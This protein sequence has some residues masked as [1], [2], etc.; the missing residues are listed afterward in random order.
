MS[1]RWRVRSGFWDFVLRAKFKST[2]D[3][4]QLPLPPDNNKRITPV[5]FEDYYTSIP[6]RSISTAD[7]LPKDERF[8]LPLFAIKVQRWIGRIFSQ[9]QSGLPPISSDDDAAL[10]GAYGEKFRTLLPAPVFPAEF[11]RDGVTDLGRFALS[12]PYSCLLERDNTGDVVWDCTDLGGYERHEG[13][14]SLAV[15]VRFTTDGTDH[16]LQAVHIEGPSGTTTPADAGWP[17][18][19]RHAMCAATTK[20][21]LVKH[22]TNIHLVCG[23]HFAVATRNELPSDH[24]ITRLVWPAI[25]G[26]QYSND[27]VME[28]QAGPRGDFVNSYSFTHAGQCKLFE[29]FNSRYGISVIDPHLDWETRGMHELG[30]NAPAQ[31]NLGELFDLVHA[32]ASRYVHHYYE[33]DESVQADRP[34]NAW[35]DHLDS[36]IPN[37]ISAFTKD[38]ITRAAVARLAGAYLYVGS[39]LHDALGTSMWNYVLWNSK[40]PI[41]IYSSGEDVPLDVFKRWVTFNFMLNVHRAPFLGDYEYF[42]LDD[43]GMAL[44]RQFRREA[45]ALQ[46]RDAQLDPACWRMVPEILEIGMNSG[47]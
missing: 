38:G 14:E 23:N 32:H 35:L 42:G 16:G 46:E 10:D 26:T 39:A 13:V 12:S 36:A 9:M 18:A 17:H 3:I 40:N 19:V 29:D 15:L 34:L 1:L 21:A 47:R 6:I 5:P 28:V 11:N 33:D 37:G 31:E 43:D 45:E 30:L 2:I 8:R 7:H 44:W 4:S 41:R 25:Y 22:F 27:L 20:L 24:P